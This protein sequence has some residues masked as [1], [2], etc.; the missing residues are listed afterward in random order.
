MLTSRTPAR[1]RLRVA[2]LSTTRAPGLDYLL[3]RD[4]QRG[5]RYDIVAFVATDP[6]HRDLTR[7]TSAGVSAATRDIRQ[8]YARAGVP[9]GDL[10]VRRDFDR[11]TASLL[12]GIH[13]DLIVSCGYLHIMTA[14]LL[15]AYPNRIINI[16]DSDLPA[17]PGLHAVRDAVFA[18][19]RRTRST[20]HLVTE[21]LDVGP[22]LLK[23]WA[24]PTHPMVTD[25][26]RWGAN[27][28]DILKAYAY[29]HREWMMRATWGPLLAQAI[30][31]FADGQVRATGGQ[32]SV[33]GTPAPLILVPEEPAARQ[34]AQAHDL[35]AA[36]AR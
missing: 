35:A 22:P 14:P 27:A 2:V 10:A 28:T 4:P 15:E 6:A 30:T 12:G 18:G 31:Y 8:F 5:R 16:H 19:E 1:P 20:V 11:G 29:A 17:Y 3:E 13:A 24:F 33:G 7:V 26:R 36:V 25:A 9:R 23:S 32:V 34:P 21:G